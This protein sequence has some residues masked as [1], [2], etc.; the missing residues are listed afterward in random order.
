M[1]DATNKQIPLW[2]Q[3][4]I[5]DLQTRKFYGKLTLEFKEGRVGLIRKEE[6]V[7][8]PTNPQE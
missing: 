1:A 8:P 7:K 3:N 4:L 5:N 6:T 2:L